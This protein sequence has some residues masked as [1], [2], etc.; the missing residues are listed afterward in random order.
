[1]HG[2]AWRAGEETIHNPQTQDKK[3]RQEFICRKAFFIKSSIKEKSAALKNKNCRGVSCASVIRYDSICGSYLHITMKEMKTKKAQ[4]CIL[5]GQ[6]PLLTQVGQDVK[7]GGKKSGE[8]MLT[9]NK[10]E[11]R[12]YLAL[13]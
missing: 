10:N 4:G 13:G 9:S 2:L 12:Y 1:M 8:E 11:P 3:F 6:C 5:R 7:D